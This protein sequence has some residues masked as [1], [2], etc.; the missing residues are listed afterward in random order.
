MLLGH[1]VGAILMAWVLARADAVVFGLCRSLHRFVVPRVCA[2]PHAGERTPRLSAPPK[3]E[4]IT[5]V[6]LLL[7]TATQ[8]RGP[9]RTVTV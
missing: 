8:Y 3:D 9:P 2:A 7:A 5:G 6:G 1:V 4:A